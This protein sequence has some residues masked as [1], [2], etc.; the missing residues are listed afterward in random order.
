MMCVCVSSRY[1][2]PVLEATPA[3]CSKDWQSAIGHIDT[4]LAKGTRR[5]KLRLKER[6]L[7]SDLTDGD[8]GA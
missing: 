8:F 5:E 2:Q 1:F 3:N 4:V 7:L 6:F